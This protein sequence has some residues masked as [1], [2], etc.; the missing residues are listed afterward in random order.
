MNRASPFCPETDTATAVPRRLLRE[1]NC[2]MASWTNW[3]GSA[4]GCVRICGYS[5]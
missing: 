3:V 5:M 4:P 1:R 2:W